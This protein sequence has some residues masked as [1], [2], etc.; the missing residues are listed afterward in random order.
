LI[1]LYG[2][3]PAA[4]IH[5]VKSEIAGFAVTIKKICS[6]MFGVF[7]AL[8]RFAANLCAGKT[9]NPL[10][11]ERSPESSLRMR[12]ITE[13]EGASLPLLFFC[14]F[15]ILIFEVKECIFS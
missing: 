4:H 1:D 6:R 7:S 15:Y 2:R 12:L 10:D 13:A 11:F 5:T 14:G 3:Q 9:C 8:V